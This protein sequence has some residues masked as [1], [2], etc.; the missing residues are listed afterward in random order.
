MTTLEFHPLADTFP[1]VGGAEF[2]ELVADI[3]EHGLHEPVDGP[4][5]LSCMRCS[6]RRAV[7]YGLLGRRSSRLCRQLEPAATAPIRI[8]AGYGGG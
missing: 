7:V 2:D 6:W 1:L 3:R 4:Q 5:S 8:A